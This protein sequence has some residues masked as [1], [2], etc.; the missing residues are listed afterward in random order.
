MHTRCNRFGREY[1]MRY[2][3]LLQ[4]IR[5]AKEKEMKKSMQ[6]RSHSGIHLHTECFFFNLQ[7][8]FHSWNFLFALHFFFWCCAAA[9]EQHWAI[10]QAQKNGLFIQRLHF[11]GAPQVDGRASDSS[12]MWPMHNNNALKEINET[13][14]IISVVFS[15]YMRWPLTSDERISI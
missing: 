13:N 10:Y 14:D 15:T 7:D 11:S 12:R 4:R 5:D 8:R 6:T 2:L 3:L 1:F 9:Y